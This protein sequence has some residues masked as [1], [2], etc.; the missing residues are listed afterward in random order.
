MSFQLVWL[1]LVFGDLC[2]H[3]QAASLCAKKGACKNVVGG[4][5]NRPI[6][7]GHQSHLG[8][9]GTCKWG[10]KATEGTC[11]PGWDCGYT[12][13]DCECVDENSAKGGHDNEAALKLWGGVACCG[14]G[15]FLLAALGVAEMNKREVAARTSMSKV[16]PADAS[17]ADHRGTPSAPSYPSGQTNRGT[18]PYQHTMAAPNAPQ[19]QFHSIIGKPSGHIDVNVHQ[20]GFR[21]GKKDEKPAET[22]TP[23]TGFEVDGC[24]GCIIMCLLVVIGVGIVLIAISFSMDSTEYYNEC[25]AE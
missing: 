7:S 11:R 19:D 6:L 4:N 16:A 2:F 9:N 23:A 21:E 3:C 15:L 1:L 12:W 20:N 25:G 8:A 13:Y 18:A 24:G 17:A 14:V 10:H 22:K 5:Q